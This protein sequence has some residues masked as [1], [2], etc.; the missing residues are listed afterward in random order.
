MCNYYAFTED[1]DDSGGGELYQNLGFRDEI[2]QNAVATI[3]TSRIASLQNYFLNNLIIKLN[4]FHLVTIR[5]MH[6]IMIFMPL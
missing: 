6:G 3:I 2:R 4:I 1:N 5:N